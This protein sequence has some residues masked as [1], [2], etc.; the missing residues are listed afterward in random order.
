MKIKNRLGC[1]IALCLSAA[2]VQ[3]QETSEVETLKKQLLQMKE[4]FEKVQ[5]DY[6]KQI[7][8][9]SKKVDE[10]LKQQAASAEKE[11][12]K[13]QLAA[14]LQKNAEPSPAKPGAAVEKEPWSPAQP[15]TVMRAGAAYMNLSFDTLID[16]GWSSESD[17][18]ERLQLGDHDPIQRGFSLRNAEIAIDGAVDPYFKGFA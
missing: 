7:D 4:N 11:K 8:A 17:P 10:L 5:Q 1:S 3:A 2:V 13:E 16:F 9:L 6:Q 15:I 18:S 12:L 14:E